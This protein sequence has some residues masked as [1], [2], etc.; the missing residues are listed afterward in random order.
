M[1]YFASD[2]FGMT[3]ARISLIAFGEKLRDDEIDGDNSFKKRIIRAL[4][5]KTIQKV[6]EEL[7][8]IKEIAKRGNDEVNELQKADAPLNE[9]LY[10]YGRAV[11]DIMQNLFGD[12][13]EGYNLIEALAEWTFFVDMLCDY[14]K[15]IKENNPNTLYREDAK[16]I[17]E[18]FDKYY[19][20]LIEQNA[21]I[22]E[23]VLEPLEKIADESYEWYAIKAIITHALDTV[24]DNIIKGEDVEFHYFNELY[25]NFKGLK[26]GRKKRKLLEEKQ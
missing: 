1:N 3:L 4:F 7:P 15:D 21:V 24:V 14:D 16:T 18:Y 22:N 8:E 25:G 26:K 20:Y 9:V 2:E 23:R 17:K 5:K 12:L 10:A 19:S 11:A 13:G 6:D